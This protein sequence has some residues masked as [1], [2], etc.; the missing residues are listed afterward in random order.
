MDS[1]HSRA[2]N[3][4]SDYLRLPL[5]GPVSTSKLLAKSDNTSDY[6]CCHPLIPEQGLAIP[7]HIFNI[8]THLGKK[9]Q[10]TSD[11]AR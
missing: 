7:I 2:Q 9:K 3:R 5:S 1:Q 6:A 8:L 4:L 10:K 11:N